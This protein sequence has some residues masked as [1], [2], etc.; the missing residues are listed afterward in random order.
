MTSLIEQFA[1]PTESRKPQT[2]SALPPRGYMIS[3]G[4]LTRDVNHDLP[5]DPA[6]E[7]TEHEQRI[8]RAIQIDTGCDRPAAVRMLARRDAIV[9]RR[10]C[11]DTSGNDFHFLPDGARKGMV[12]CDP[13]CRR[14]FEDAQKAA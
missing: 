7:W 6:K 4:S 14:Q 9:S 2:I 13:D 12:F 11:G 10:F 8:I 3:S 1:T 5:Q